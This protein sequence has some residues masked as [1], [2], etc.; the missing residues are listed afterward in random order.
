VMSNLGLERYLRT[1]DLALVR[2]PV[3][4]RYVAEEM[5][6]RRC[7]LG[8]EQSGHIILGD[9]STTG[10]GLIAALQVLAAIVETERRPSE[11]CGVFRPVPQ[12]LVN[13]RVEDLSALEDVRVMRAIEDGE[14]QLGEGGRLLVRKSGTEPLIR[15]MAEGEDEKLVASVVDAVASVVRSAGG[16][17]QRAA[18]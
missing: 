18:E 9:H 15:I 8:G 17:G 2:S 5:R 16:T 4:D 3:G 7:N 1:L 6:R 11:L 13:V 14:R 12:R 10:D